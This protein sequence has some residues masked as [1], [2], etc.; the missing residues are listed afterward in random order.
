MGKKTR[1]NLHCHPTLVGNCTY[2]DKPRIL[3]VVKKAGQELG[4]NGVLVVTCGW[5]Q[6]DRFERGLKEC[7]RLPE[8]W[9]YSYKD[10]VLRLEDKDTGFGFYLVK[11]YEFDTK[12]GHLLTIARL[13]K[14]DAKHLYAGSKKMDSVEVAKAI[15]K[16]DKGAVITIP[17]GFCKPGKLGVGA[18]GIKKLV[19][20]GLVDGIEWTAQ[21]FTGNKKLAYFL[22]N[23]SEVKKLAAKSGTNITNLVATTDSCNIRAPAFSGDPSTLARSYIEV[24][25]LDFNGNW[26][27]QLRGTIRKGEFKSV[28]KPISIPEFVGWSASRFLR[29]LSGYRL[30]RNE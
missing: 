26:I 2:A 17:H 29:Y 21:P 13:G 25:E 20:E 27:N 24:P 14:E 3:E 15:R 18:E 16:K 30:F 12:E 4:N 11:G 9:K 8:N 10:G 1:I 19:G 28:K 22:E 23:D 7:R 6:Q 5:D